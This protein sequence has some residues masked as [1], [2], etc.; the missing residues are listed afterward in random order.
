MDI[1]CKFLKQVGPN[2]RVGWRK[3]A[4][5]L[6]RVGLKKVERVEKVQVGWEKSENSNW[7]YSFIWHPRVSQYVLK[8]PF[9]KCKLYI[10][11]CKNSKMASLDIEWKPLQIH[12]TMNVK[13]FVHFFEHYLASLRAKWIYDYKIAME[14]RVKLVLSWNFL[15]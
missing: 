4:V 1:L 5:N 9:P 8:S 10:S 12:Q 6:K 11:T 13:V 7:V 14:T 15:V 2:K 3:K